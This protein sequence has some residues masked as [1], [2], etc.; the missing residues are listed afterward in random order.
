MKKFFTEEDIDRTRRAFY[1]FY[2]DNETSGL[3]IFN[4]LDEELTLVEVKEIIDGLKKAYLNINEVEYKKRTLE[5]IEYDI[6]FLFKE[7]E[8]GPN[9]S[10]NF[11]KNIKRQYVIECT[12]CLKKISSKTEKGYWIAQ[13]YHKQIYRK[14]FC[15]EWCVLK[16][17]NEVKQSSIKAKKIR[18]GL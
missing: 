2:H 6:D 17:I 3:R 9:I 5:Q 16:Y 8:F 13:N 15:S 11:R 4:G 18:Y 10:E 12:N 14:K 7:S 1:R